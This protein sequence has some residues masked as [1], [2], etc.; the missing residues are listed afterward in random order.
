MIETMS[1]PFQSDAC[2]LFGA[3][4]DLAFKQ[5][6]PALQAMTRRGH[7]EMPVII[8]ARSGWSLDQ[9]KARMRKSLEQHGSLDGDVFAKLTSRLEY[10]DGDYGDEST[11]VR[12]RTILATRNIRS[13]TWPFRQACSKRSPEVLP[14][15]AAPMALASL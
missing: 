2:V 6:F 14:N 12:L 3:T 15:R 13:I 1:N 9:L 4:G 8:V 11:Y 7:L 5:I 10:V